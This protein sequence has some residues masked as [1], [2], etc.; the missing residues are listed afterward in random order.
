M[1]EPTTKPPASCGWTE[2]ATSTSTGAVL[3][4]RVFNPHVAGRRASAVTD[5]WTSITWG[6]TS[7]GLV[8]PRAVCF[9]HRRGFFT[10][11]GVNTLEEMVDKVRIAFYREILKHGFKR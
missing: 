3:R 10:I 6:D 2:H 9:P 7:A 11:G 4:S 8:I 1:P 5:I